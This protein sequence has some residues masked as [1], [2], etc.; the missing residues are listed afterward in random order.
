[1]TLLP[2]EAGRL[3]R[4]CAGGGAWVAHCEAVAAA[5]DGLAAMI[6]SGM[7]C[8]RSFVRTAGLL[9]DIG[10]CRTHD[11]VGHGI[12]GFEL[13]S[14]AGHHREARVCASHILCGLTR[15]EAVAC[16]LPDRDFMPVTIEER[17]VVL[18]DLLVEFD[19][20]TTVARRFASLRARYA[21][22]DRFLAALARAETRTAALLAEIGLFTGVQPEET[23]RTVL[24]GR[25]SDSPSFRL[26]GIL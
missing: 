6:D 1:M 7:P 10:R 4:D 12:A 2:A 17:L 15:D 25:L 18:A 11:P 5:A 24:E 20:P 14:E 23:V 13:L 26:D 21:G 19:R 22:N 3:L 9:H 16:G 8:D